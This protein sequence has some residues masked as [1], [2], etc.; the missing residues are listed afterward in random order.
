MKNEI[1]VDNRNYRKHN[2]K[3]KDL[4]KKSLTECGTGRSILIDAENKIIAGNGTFEQAEKLG[5][6]VKVIESNG[7]I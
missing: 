5:L 2:K 3:N 4:I 6:K 7:L 1:R